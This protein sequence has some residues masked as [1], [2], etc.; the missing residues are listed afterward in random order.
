MDR[1]TESL[2]K[3]HF[4][5]TQCGACC[6]RA[7]ELELGEASAYADTFVLQLMMRIYSLPRSLA[8]YEC[9]LS[10]ELAS[11]E[12]Y[13][14]KRLLG[15]YAAASWPIKAVRGGRAVE[16]VQ[17]LNLSVLPLDIG[18]GSCP[19]L[20]GTSCS[21]YER[22]PLSCRTVPVHYSRPEA[23]AVRDL[24]AF[25]AKAGFLCQ[26]TCEAPVIIENGRLTD[27]ATLEARAA[28]DQQ[29]S[30]DARWK[31]ALVKAMKA[32][33]HALPTPREVEAQ[34]ARGALISSMR[35]A[36]RVAFEAGLLDA[37]R[38]EALAGAQSALIDR[39]LSYRNLTPAAVASLADLLREYRLSGT[40]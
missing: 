7:P 15:T 27:P 33:R 24:D 4:A 28:A 9:A 32:K 8:D 13:E 5:C 38:A 1:R 3:R 14:S 6:N 37:E 25:T 21:I 29:A 22:R 31:A 26:T 30:T 10:R 2:T 34:A 36:W 20:D 19:A 39:T 12:Y 16:Y 17:Y 35:V 40:S 11:A 23:A 18:T